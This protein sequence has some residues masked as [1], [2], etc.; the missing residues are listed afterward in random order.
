MK[1]IALIVIVLAVLTGSLRA[2]E[3]GVTAGTMGKNGAFH[4]G[5]AVGSG[6][7]V[8]M[9]KLEIEYYKVKDADFL[10]EPGATTVGIKFRPKMGKISPYGIVGVG[11]E[12][13]SFGF[14]F[15]DYD[16]FTFV[17]G[18]VHFYM[19]DMMSLRA[20]VRFLHFSDRNVTRISAGIFFHL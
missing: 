2:V 15:G 10:V 5:F 7:F 20:D 3:L 16:K 9:L 8:P 13:E 11:S 12:F 6:L 18:G 19:M 17:G 14:D 1:R 4:Y